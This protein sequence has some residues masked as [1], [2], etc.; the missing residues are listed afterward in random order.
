MHEDNAELYELHKAQ[1][2]V[3]V[4]KQG[5]IRAGHVQRRTEDRAVK[6]VFIG[7]PGG[8]INSV[9]FRCLHSL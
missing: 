3:T 5:T 8:P 7:G 2:I 1:D 4:I 6:K 9:M